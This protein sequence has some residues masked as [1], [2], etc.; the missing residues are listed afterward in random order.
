MPTVRKQR[1]EDSKFKASLD[2]TDPVSKNQKMDLQ[3]SGRVSAVHI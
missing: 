2:Y 1:Q 3:L